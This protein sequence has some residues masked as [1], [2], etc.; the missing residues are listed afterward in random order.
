VIVE[1]HA[2]GDLP[3]LE[4]VV[5]GATTVTALPAIGLLAVFVLGSE[6]VLGLAFGDFYRSAATVLVL[7]SLERLVFVW[8]G[9]CG[10][11]LLMTGHETAVM[12]ISVSTGI[13][14]VVLAWAGARAFG[15]EGAAAGYA[16]GSITQQL[17]AW[18]TVR[19]R[20]GIRT[21]VTLRGLPEA[22]SAV[23]RS[24]GR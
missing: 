1:L 23:R 5:R 22:I 24:L 11:T 7:L 15:L 12:K 2:G 6:P 10:L 14:T 21:S 19:R 17:L 4:R 9:P 8:V 16:L 13:A 18:H 3:R 20:V